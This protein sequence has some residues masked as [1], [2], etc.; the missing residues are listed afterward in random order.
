ME[1]VAAI[2]SGAPVNCEGHSLPSEE[3]GTCPVGPRAGE[4]WTVACAPVTI[5]EDVPAPVHSLNWAA[6]VAEIG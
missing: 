5:V 1:R 4:G 6:W 2:R 3:I